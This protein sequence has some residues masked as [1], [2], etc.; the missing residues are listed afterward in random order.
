MLYIFQQGKITLPFSC[1]LSPRLL[2][3]PNLQ[4]TIPNSR[5]QSCGLLEGC[6]MKRPYNKNISKLYA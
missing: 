6:F 5:N 4:L 3:Y 2:S 1:F